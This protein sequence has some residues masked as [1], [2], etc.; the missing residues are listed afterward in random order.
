MCESLDHKIPRNAVKR[1]EA[2]SPPVFL[3]I[4]DIREKFHQAGVSFSA[5][6]IKAQL[7]SLLAATGNPDSGPTLPE[8]LPAGG[9]HGRGGI[10][11]RN[12]F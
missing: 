6:A 8:T 4:T 9:I 3:T 1:K 10:K 12:Q 5:K 2:R 7:S 11:E